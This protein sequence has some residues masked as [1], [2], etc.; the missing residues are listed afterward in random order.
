MLR[1]RIASVVGLALQLSCL[2]CS[3]QAAAQADLSSPV[4]SERIQ[5]ELKAIEN[6]TSHHATD[7]ELGELWGL[8]A[9]DYQHEMDIP[10]AE[11]AY[12]HSLKLLRVSVTARRNYAAVLDGLGSLYLLTGQIAESEN[13]RRKAL[14]I[15]DAVGDRKNSLV[16]HGNL[17]A[18]LLK[19]GKFKDAETEA[20]NV[21]EGMLGQEKP[22]ATDLVSALI[23]RSYAR[24]LQHR[25]KEGLSDATQAFDIVQ[26]FLSPNSLAAA[27][28]WSTLGY[29]EWKSGDVAGCD[30]KMRRALQVLSDKNGDVPYPV[31]VDSRIGA[32]QEYRQF[33][34]ETH[35]K[36]EA[37]QVED[38]MARLTREQ[39]PACR[40]C[41]VNVEGLT[42]TS[43]GR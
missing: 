22:Y 18:T 23:V 11:E 3:T 4:T 21:I 33:L 32:L 12:D 19:E 9:S 24:C 13:C 37:R 42:T 26:A 34:N 14:A 1:K 17:A 5:A 29:M 25:C 27:S 7:D 16:L 30:E 31:L 40:N 35:R 36:P 41:T 10:R 15:L 8:L 20:S 28:S 38:E 39:T 43:A 2:L 6:A